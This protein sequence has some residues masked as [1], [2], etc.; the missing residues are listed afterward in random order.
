MRFG[1]HSMTVKSL[2]ADLT[3]EKLR[4]ETVNGR[5]DPQPQR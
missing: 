1:Q 3:S 5:F 4:L 2:R